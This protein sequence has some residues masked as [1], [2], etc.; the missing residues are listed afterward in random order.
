MIK[1]GWTVDEKL[2][3]V[4]E[5]G[6]IC[7]LD[8]TGSVAQISLGE[9]AKE[10]GI[11][12]AVVRSNELVVLTNQFKFICISNLNEPRP[13]QMADPLLTAAPNSW[14]I[15]PSDQGNSGYL[16]VF[17]AAKNSILIIDQANAVDQKM[18]GEFQ[19]MSLSPNGKFIALFTK[20]AR[21]LV[22]STDFQVSLADLQTNSDSPPIQMAWCGNDAVILHWED[23]LLIVGPSAYHQKFLYDGMVLL[24]QEMDSVRVISS[25]SCEIIQRVSEIS[26]SIFQFGSEAP[27]AI[28]FDAREQFDKKNSKSEEYV[29]SIRVSLR[30]AVDDCIEAAGSEFD[31]D[32][33]KSLLKAASFGKGF[34]DNYPSSK[35]VDMGKSLR[36]LNSVR[37]HIIGLPLTY[38]QYRQ[39]TPEKLVYTLCQRHHYGLAKAI[40]EMLNVPIDRVLI[41]WA[42][43][44]V[45][46]SA[47]DEETLT[48]AIFA[49]LSDFSSVSYSEVAKEAYSVGKIKLAT[50]V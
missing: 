4:F 46:T 39:M 7:L 44:K 8:I 5:Q 22:V 24:Q 16:E 45:R 27:G 2:V 43:H 23:T 42:C 33:Q 9:D 1:M 34:L 28:L 15:M 20:D 10:F 14:D 30:K 50:N 19:Q 40:C 32:V 11:H 13:K 38:D 21:L 48:R 36:I 17:C 29:R 6:Y 26:E 12:D 18:L 41:H 25:T 49:K 35:F 31:T 3:C 47:D 37:N